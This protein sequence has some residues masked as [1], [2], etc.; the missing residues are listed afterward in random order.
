MTW[1]QFLLVNSHQL[2]FSV[3]ER[4]KETTI[5]IYFHATVCFKK[6]KAPYHLVQLLKQCSVGKD[7]IL[8]PTN[9]HA[10]Y[11]QQRAVADLSKESC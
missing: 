8:E 10:N 9:S 2:T 4:R 7:L 3:I 5:G 11:Q 6:K 1:I